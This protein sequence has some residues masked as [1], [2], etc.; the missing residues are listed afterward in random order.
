MVMSTLWLF[1]FH[2]GF[3]VGVFLVSLIIGTLVIYLRKEKPRTSMHEVRDALP[4]A[5]QPIKP[6]VVIRHEPDDGS[7]DAAGKPAE[8]FEAIEVIFPLRQTAGTPRH[9]FTNSHSV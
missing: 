2:I 6:L 9:V 1:F 3:V 5:K 4:D 8:E 7:Q